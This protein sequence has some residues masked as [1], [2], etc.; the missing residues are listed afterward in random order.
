MFFWEENERAEIR[1]GKK[2]PAFFPEVLDQHNC[3]N[4][5]NMEAWESQRI[6]TNYILILTDLLF[7]PVYFFNNFENKHQN[8]IKTNCSN[9]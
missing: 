3:I 8:S 2:T 9:F 7:L 1:I 6:D 5:W 4:F